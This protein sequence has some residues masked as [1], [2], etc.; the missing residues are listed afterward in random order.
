MHVSWVTELNTLHTCIWLKTL[1][2]RYSSFMVAER[3]LDASPPETESSHPYA[4]PFRTMASSALEQMVASEDF[5]PTLIT[6]FPGPS[7]EVAGDA[8][9]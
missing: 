9:L 1:F 5:I 6:H 2:C 3:L 4:A 8:H 7:E